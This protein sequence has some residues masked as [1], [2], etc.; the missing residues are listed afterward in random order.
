MAKYIKD[1]TGLRFG[2]LLVI[3]PDEKAVSGK[4]MWIC[5][6]DCGN[7][8]SIPGA[9]LRKGVVTSCGCLQAEARIRNAETARDKK[10]QI[11]STMHGCTWNEHTCFAYGENGGCLALTD[12][13]FPGREKCP[14]YKDRIQYLHECAEAEKRKKRGGL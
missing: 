5:K 10:E 11:N 6:C 4:M 7:E 1:L 12:T 3:G 13:L 9:N 14:F 8:K 2:R